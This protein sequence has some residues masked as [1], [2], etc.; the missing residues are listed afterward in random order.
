MLSEDRRHGKGFLLHD[1]KLIYTKLCE[2]G[3]LER[4]MNDVERKKVV[5]YLYETEGKIMK[6]QDSCTQF[7]VSLRRL[8]HAVSANEHEKNDARSKDGSELFAG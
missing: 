2:I 3:I 4:T 8:A 6:V 7:R 5:R 1:R